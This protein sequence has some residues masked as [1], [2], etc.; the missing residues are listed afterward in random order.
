[1]KNFVVMLV[2]SLM[3]ISIITSCGQKSEEDLFATAEQMEMEEKFEDALV[4]YERILVEYPNTEKAADI[5]FRIA[6]LSGNLKRFQRCVDSYEK[7]IELNPDHPMAPKA[8]FM[9]GYIYANELKNMGKAKRAYEKFLESYADVDS[10]MTASA[11]FELKYMGKDISEIDFLNDLASKSET[12][13]TE[14]SN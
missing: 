4:K 3:I 9:V 12:K 10:G 2:S 14:K 5:Y 1:M 7:I 11:N 13:T 8:Q 6:Q